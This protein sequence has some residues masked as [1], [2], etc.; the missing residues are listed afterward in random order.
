MVVILCYFD[1]AGEVSVRRETSFTVI[2]SLGADGTDTIVGENKLCE[3]RTLRVERGPQHKLWE[4]PIK[5]LHK[6][7][8][9][10]TNRSFSSS[11][12]LK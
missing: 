2:R 1:F 5:C 3:V 9:T 11:A 12:H 8:H 4:F 10:V 6:I 7:R